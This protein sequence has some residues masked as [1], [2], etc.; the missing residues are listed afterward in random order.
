[1]PH[2]ATAKGQGRREAKGYR[3]EEEEDEKER[4]KDVVTGWIRKS[5]KKRSGEE[6]TYLGKGRNVSQEESTRD[7]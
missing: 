5:E 4:G 1:M 3:E 6:N 7:Q 2:G